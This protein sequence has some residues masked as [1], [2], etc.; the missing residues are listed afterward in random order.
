MLG[1]GNGTWGYEEEEEQMRAEEAAFHTVR[2]KGLNN[3]KGGQQY[4]HNPTLEKWYKTSHANQHRKDTHTS[5]PK[6][7]P[8][9]RD[10]EIRAHK[11]R[12]HRNR[13]LLHKYS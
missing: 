3:T 7:R 9:A 13:S 4:P 11:R 8:G 1:N 10:D 2:E 6:N 12:H 5:S